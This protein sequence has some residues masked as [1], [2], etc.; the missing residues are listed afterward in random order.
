M[1]GWKAKSGMPTR[2]T[3]LPGR[4]AKM[5]VPAAHFVNKAPLIPFEFVDV[6][7]VFANPSR[8]LL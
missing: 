5:P 4:P 6:Q 3:A 1:F 8:S 2:E 7:E